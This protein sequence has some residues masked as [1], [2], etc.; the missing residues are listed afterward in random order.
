MQSPRKVKSYMPFN[1]DNHFFQASSYDI[2][3]N[4]WDDEPVNVYLKSTLPITCAES[5]T[6]NQPC[7]KAFPT[8]SNGK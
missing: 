5:N 4:E 1:D 6:I 3:V 8:Q 7:Y 2:I